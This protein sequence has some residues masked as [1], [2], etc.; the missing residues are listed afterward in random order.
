M[1]ISSFALL[2]LLSL[3]ACTGTVEEHLTEGVSQSL[4]SRRGLEVSDVHYD[5]QF[6]IPAD[7]SL[8]VEGEVD[9]TFRWKGKNDLPLDFSGEADNLYAVRV[10]G[11]SVEV[12]FRNEH[13]VVPAQLLE[14]GE[15][16]IGVR[17]TS[18]DK[19]LNRHDDYLYTLFV[20]DNARSAFPC[21]DQP[22]L[23]ATYSLS[24][25]LPQ[26][27]E[28][29]SQAPFSIGQQ[30]L[31][32]GYKTLTCR[33]Q[34]PVPTYLVSFT[35][36][37]FFRVEAERDGRTLELLHRET[38]SRKVA[39]LET[40]FDEAALALRWME[41]YTGIP[42]PYEKYGCVVLPGYQFGGM[43][44]PGAIQ[45]NANTIFLGPQPTPDEELARLNLIAHETAHMWFGDM[46]TMCWFDDVWTKEVF[47]NL[48]ADKIAREQFP[49]LN[50]NL[51]F[52]KSHY[53]AAL[54]TDRTSGTTPIQQPLQNLNQASLLYGNIIYH[55][56][57]IMM[58]KMEEQMG[59]EAFRDGLRAYLTRY[60]YANATW[61]G[62][63]E[64][65]DSVAP[66]AGL[67]A[68]SQ[69]WVKEAGLPT[70]GWERRG[71][72]LVVTQ[73]DP[74][75]RGLTWPQ[76]LTFAN[77]RAPQVT[78]PNYDGFGYGRFLFP[79][80]TSLQQYLEQ[81]ELLE[82]EESRFAAL[83][84]IYENYLAGN[85]PADNMAWCV[86][87]PMGQE[88]NPL[89]LSYAIDC[90]AAA[91]PYV[92]SR[93][94]FEE[95]LL[96]MSQQHPQQAVRQ[97]I[98][99][100]LGT[101]ARSEKVVEAVYSL[102]AEQSDVSLSER[103]Y[104][105]MAYHLA[106]VR[107][108]DWQDIL[109]KQRERLHSEDLRREFDYVSRACNPDTLVQQQLFDELLVPE[110]RTSEPWARD[111]LALLCDESRE[112]MCLR[113]LRPGL[114]ALPQIQ[115]SSGIFF[116]GYWLSAL[117][118]GQHSQDASQ[119]VQ[120]WISEH[121]DMHAPLLNKVKEQAYYMGQRSK[122]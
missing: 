43:E 82:T 57:P 108:E 42:F 53:P 104:M 70:I 48:M 24:L 12:G 2:G 118:S 20:P 91:L 8:P 119:T 51:T 106:L 31:D 14:A 26:D 103:D 81:Q 84:N 15:N 112:P 75:E 63:I 34:W 25:T 113:Y 18:T 46:V 62:L 39:Q 105:Q 69:V 33:T 72:S 98:V 80:E 107:S 94:G 79:D 38:D 121:A 7:A 60:A 41:E 44:H 89:I 29:I 5:L 40:V 87:W 22:D 45:F 67:P 13:I 23:K 28:A 56:A 115:R 10:N 37:R 30:A 109:G 74:L 78:L 9:I 16:R 47:A 65:L 90:L 116:P 86:Y 59:N 64:I 111:L 17:F 58:R 99:R 36:G 19:A 122:E 117:L 114:D 21:F 6:H 110:N 68:F 76:S 3:S 120:E 71:D 27:W 66:H 93:Q 100:L 92:S 83:M 77:P 1:K 55:K 85:I 88:Q 102:W 32:E 54:R 11:Y 96:S 35:A 101:K 61:D 95:M 49:D 4:A 52:I 73:R 97:K 50:H